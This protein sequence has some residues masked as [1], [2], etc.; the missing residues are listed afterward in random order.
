MK[1]VSTYYPRRFWYRKPKKWRPIPTS[2]SQ[3][4]TKGGESFG[5][6]DQKPT[7]QESN[8]TVHQREWEV[9]QSSG[10]NLLHP[11]GTE[12][13]EHDPQSHRE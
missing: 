9:H 11:F 12:N 7:E 10:I 13:Q 5:N 6:T 3:T 1:R 8:Q 4:E 2:L